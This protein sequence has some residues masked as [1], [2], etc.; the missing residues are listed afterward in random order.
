MRVK[1]ILIVVVWLSV[2]LVAGGTR[3]QAPP[4]FNP[5]CKAFLAGAAARWDYQINQWTFDGIDIT[6]PDWDEACQAF[7]KIQSRWP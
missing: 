5:Q 1:L 3:T 4:P 6:D 7:L 2:S